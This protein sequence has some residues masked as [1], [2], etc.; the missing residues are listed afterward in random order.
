MGG[1]GERRVD[2]SWIVVS[3][4]SARDLPVLLRSLVTALRE[5]N[6][7]GLSCELL[8]VDNGSSDGSADL[9]ARLVPWATRVANPD[10]RGYGAAI[11]QALELA[12]GRW[13]AFGNAD[14]FVPAGALARL[15]DVLAAQPPEVAVVGPALFGSDGRRELSAGHFPCMSS[16]LTGLLRACHRRKYVHERRHVRGPV[17][18]VTGACLFARTELLCEVGGFDED[19]F[20]YYED[21]DLARRLA[22]R[23]G[24]TVFEP[25]LAVVHVR[26]HHGRPPVPAIEQIV[27]QSRRAYFERHRPR[28]EQAALAWLGRLEP[29]LRRRSRLSP[30]PPPLPRPHPGV[31]RAVPSTAWNLA[32]LPAVGV[33][34]ARPPQGEPVAQPVLGVPAA[35]HAAPVLVPRPATVVASVLPSGQ[36]AA[37]PA[38]QRPAAALAVTRE[39]PSSDDGLKVRSA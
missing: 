17:D 28:W 1:P 21:V 6:E 20:L 5:L 16:L 31:V 9:A 15:P 39:P 29:L 2:L 19:Y 11:N 7:R 13:V 30:A 24:V 18:W 26:P 32:P 10:N 34:A 27:R 8:V 12:A 14:L 35:P 3:H 36:P 4:E 25:D 22:L 33:A 23:G 37:S 38:A